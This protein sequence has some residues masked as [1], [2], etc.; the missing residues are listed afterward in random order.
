MNI[1]KTK[2][3]CTIGP[4]SASEIILKKLIKSGMNVARLNFSHGDYDSHKKLI[5][6]I[7]KVAQE[8]NK[9]IAIIQDL[10]GPR[11]RVAKIS[12]KGLDLIKDEKVIIT[13]KQYLKDINIKGLDYKVIPLDYKYIAEDVNKEDNILINDG[14]I[15][16]KVIEVNKNL[17]YCK[18]VK[19]G[20]IFSY[21]GINIPGVK[22][23]ENVITKKD[24][25][26]LAFGLKNK[27]DFIA[28]SFVEN[29]HNIIELKK[30]IKNYKLQNDIKVIAKIERM[31]AFLDRKNIIKYADGIMIA[32]GDLGIEIPDA[33]VPIVQKELISN[34]LDVGK[35]VIVA[36]QMLDSMINNPKPTRAEVS[37]VANAV[38]DGTDAVMLSGETAFG[39][40]PLETVK[41]MSDIILETESSSYDLIG[42][43][44]NVNKEVEN[45]DSKDIIYAITD[46]VF[47]LVQRLNAKHIVVATKSGFTARMV[48]RYRPGVT[49]M[50]MVADE[51]VSRHLALVWGV[52]TFKIKHCS[53]FDEIINESINKLK[54]EKLIK[55]NDKL[56]FITGQPI[57]KAHNMNLIKL[58]T[59]K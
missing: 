44:I 25:E 47:R 22:I 24:K 50:V 40:Y 53:N 55:I 15:R 43:T 35:P 32:R 14:L 12:S 4:A 17:V 49:I 42:N 38:I 27:V 18:V 19:G 51:Q 16:I 8:L 10:Q 28:I 33:K 52:Y 59:V 34:C 5:N 58:H 9:N 3:I 2:I 41:M 39:K 23:K 20:L 46:S 30:L 31:S 56:V 36:T 54:I 29:Y 13:S 48:A 7:K 21:K 57:S 26:D 1:K 11:I 45:I 37:D 6:R